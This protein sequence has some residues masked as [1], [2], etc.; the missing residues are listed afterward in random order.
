MGKMSENELIVAVKAYNFED[1]NKYFQNNPNPDNELLYKALKN[2]EYNDNENEVLKEEF[3]KMIK[4]HIKSYSY[5]SVVD[6][7]DEVIQTCGGKMNS[8]LMSDIAKKEN[9][10]E[11]C[12][13]I[14]YGFYT[15][16]ELNYRNENGKTLIHQ[17]L[18][19]DLSVEDACNILKNLVKAGANIH[20]PDHEGKTPFIVLCEYFHRIFRTYYGSCDKYTSDIFDLFFEHPKL[21]INYRDNMGKNPLIYSS[22]P[23]RSLAKK[24]LQHKFIDVNVQNCDGLSALHYSVGQGRI[25]VVKLLLDNPNIDVNI[26]N[27]RGNTPLMWVLKDFKYDKHKE[28]ME[29]LLNHPDIDLTLVD[30]DGNGILGLVEKHCRNSPDIMS[31]CLE[32][33]QKATNEKRRRRE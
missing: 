13:K 15:L 28:I 10:Y 2:A 18:E 25:D 1:V 4:S 29:M 17:L 24:L 33:Y 9:L 30:N 3:M 21:N 22:G 32:K 19:C 5:E 20:L 8:R 14:K 16:R 27:N 6:T 26:R 23:H 31:K 7:D 12:E 11:I